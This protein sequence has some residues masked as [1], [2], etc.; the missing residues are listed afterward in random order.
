MDH[1]SGNTKRHNTYRECQIPRSQGAHLG[2][3]KVRN[4]L[5]K[6]G[7]PVWVLGAAEA[8]KGWAVSQGLMTA[9][10]A[11]A[12][13][14]SGA[15]AAGG[16]AALTGLGWLAV[17]GAVVV[18]VVLIVGVGELVKKATAAPASPPPPAVLSSPSNIEEPDK[19]AAPY[20]KKDLQGEV[21]EFM[22]TPDKTPQTPAPSG[23]SSGTGSVKAPAG[24]VM[25]PTGTSEEGGSSI[26]LADSPSETPSETPLPPTPDD[27]SMGGGGG[28]D[29]GIAQH[30]PPAGVGDST[31]IAAAPPPTD[32]HTQPPPDDPSIGGTAHPT[33]EAQQI[34]PPAAPPADASMG[35]TTHHPT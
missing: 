24:N 14:G 33:G 12:A 20:K 8:V 10:G 31:K 19:F 25:A 30:E 11:A 32:Q 13:T 18:A 2:R 27:S 17:G 9:G 5:A 21:D 26:Q 6:I 34:P 23:G 3:E 35:G 7:W 22:N 4:E 1:V 28:G 29:S 15:A 16:G